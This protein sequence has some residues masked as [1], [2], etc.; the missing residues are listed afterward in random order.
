MFTEWLDLNSFRRSTT[1]LKA[2]RGGDGRAIN[3]CRARIAVV[4][5][6][7]NVADQL[8]ELPPAFLVRLCSNNVRLRGRGSAS[9]GVFV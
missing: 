6:I 8:P 2:K 4:G 1:P 3:G 9:F 5:E 7:P